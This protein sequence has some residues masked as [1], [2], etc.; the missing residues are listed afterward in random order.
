[1]CLFTTEITAIDV[2]HH[3]HYDKPGL[4][5]GKVYFKLASY[6]RMMAQ[7]NKYQNINLSLSIDYQ[8]QIFFKI[9][10]HGLHWKR[11]D[12][13]TLLTFAQPKL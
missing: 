7:F 2:C 11:C 12:F 5:L 10:S 13:G 6:A 3:F 8:A 4:C 1:M 9:R